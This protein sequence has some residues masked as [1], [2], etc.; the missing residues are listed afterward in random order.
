MWSVN[1]IRRMNRKTEFQRLCE[2][3]AL[4]KHKKQ[5]ADLEDEQI[6]EIAKYVRNGGK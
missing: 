5:L 2:K 3:V 6:A 4:R 1:E